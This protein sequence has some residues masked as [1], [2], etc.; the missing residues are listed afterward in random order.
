[1]CTVP[2]QINEMKWDNG[3]LCMLHY[4]D[5]GGGLRELHHDADE[6][7]HIIHTQVLWG[8]GVNGLHRDTQRGTVSL[9]LRG[10]YDFLELHTLDS[11]QVKPLRDNRWFTMGSQTVY[12]HTHTHTHAHIISKYLCITIDYLAHDVCSS[13]TNR[14]EEYLNHITVSLSQ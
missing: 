12:T 11:D 13:G 4:R 10:I 3:C 7:Q 1:M 8:E 5:E 9:M 6:M 2:L 14:R